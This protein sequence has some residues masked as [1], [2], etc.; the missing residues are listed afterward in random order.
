MF[1]HVC[2]VLYLCMGWFDRFDPRKCSYNY[3]WEESWSVLLFTA[4]S[5]HPGV[6]DRTSE[7]SHWVQGSHNYLWEKF[8]SALL[9]MVEFDHPELIDRTLKFNYWVQGSHNYVR[10]VLTCALVYGRV[11]SSWG[12]WQDVKIQLLSHSPLTP[13][14]LMQWVPLK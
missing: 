13:L 6:T 9:F 8:W 5:N 14:S 7:F 10:R 4:G 12:D 1:L 11:W 2:C 3:M